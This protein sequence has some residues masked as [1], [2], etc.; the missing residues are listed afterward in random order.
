[1]F[2]LRYVVTFLLHI[3]ALKTVLAEDTPDGFPETL[4]KETFKNTLQNGLHIVEFFSPYCDHCKAL[5]PKWKE[6]WQKFHEEGEK[7]GIAFNQV[8]CIESGDLCDEE[9]ISY[10]PEIRLYNKNGFIKE[11]PERAKRTVE[12]MIKYARKEVA[13]SDNYDSEEME[14][15]KSAEIEDIEFIDMIAG[16]GKETYLISFWPTVDVENFDVGVQNTF[17]DC[18]NCIPFQRTWNKV[19]NE[20]ALVG[21]KTGHLNCVKYKRLCKQLGFKDLTAE[22]SNGRPRNPRVALVLPDKAT[23]NLFMFNQEFTI[24]TKPYI[25]FAKSLHENNK[26]SSISVRELESLAD[27]TFNFDPNALLKIDSGRV[28]LVFAYDEK[29]VVPE[30]FHVLEYLLEPLTK[31]PQIT[32]YKSTDN[33]FTSIKRR[34]STLSRNTKKV[35]EDYV[36]LKSISQLPTFFIFK[37]GELVPEVYHGYST[38]EMRNPE[39]IMKWVKENSLPFITKVD[40][41]NFQDLINF[42]ND[43]FSSMTL[44]MVNDTQD[45]P[46][47]KMSETDLKNLVSGHYDFENERIEYMYDLILERRSKKK[48]LVKELKEKKG[49]DQEAVSAMRYEILHE[50]SLRSFIGYMTVSMANEILTETFD[51]P[52]NLNLTSGQIAIIDTANKRLFLN[53]INGTRLHSAGRELFAKSLLS[54]NIP[55]KFGDLNY[56]NALNY[57]SLSETRSPSRHFSIFNILTFIFVTA[58]CLL[59]RKQY[60]NRKI[61]NHYNA[62]RNTIG[63]LGRRDKKEKKFSE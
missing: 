3:I 4:T 34:Y 56:L 15:S 27:Y 45:E 43:I 21:V 28:H 35:N 20:L 13:N 42:E 63:I 31:Y 59:C 17:S 14:T 26:L 36:E 39:L 49:G 54:I 40:S 9:D 37:D 44:L 55:E 57:F 8:D 10:Y 53:D 48:K 18:D 29:T 16:K 11:Y 2:V 58:I 22:M 62:K 60:Q 41:G 32:L 30:D 50:D 23:N 51:T 25:E 52:L 61:R 7:L 19:S 5:A 1:M 33:L 47:R 24:E 46:N 12:N 6:T 38:T